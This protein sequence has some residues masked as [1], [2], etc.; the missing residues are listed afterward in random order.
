[1]APYLIN[2]PSGSRLGGTHQYGPLG[3]C[4]A[5]CSDAIFVCMNRIAALPLASAVVVLSLVGI[6]V[7][8]LLGG[9][10]S[11]T[12]R[13]PEVDR[14]KL[15]MRPENGSGVSGSAS[16]EPMPEG[17][18]VRLKLHGL[19]RPGTFYLAHIHPGTCAQGEEEEEAEEHEHGASA[20]IEIPLSQV[21]SEQNG[22]GSSTTTLWDTSVEKL[23]SGKPKHVNVHEA[24]TGNP[25]VLA[26]AD[27][28]RA[29]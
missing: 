25:P 26:C 8:F 1:M 9:P 14:A 7:G 10:G 23:F 6:L 4:A 19:P 27:L 20:E 24:G 29:G 18:V 2:R 13:G 28:K 22:E 3:G 12:D 21:K 16:L 15:D 5:L 11:Q 17:V